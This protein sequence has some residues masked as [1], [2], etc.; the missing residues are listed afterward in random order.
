[1]TAIPPDPVS[2]HW[3]QYRTYGT[4]CALSHANN[5]FGAQDRRPACGA[6]FAGY[7]RG[8]RITVTAR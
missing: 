7:G 1:V 2:Y 4:G 6:R 3:Q 5:R 8:E